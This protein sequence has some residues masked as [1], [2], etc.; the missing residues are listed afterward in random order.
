MFDSIPE[1]L[2]ALQQ[3]VC[4]SI[5]PPL[6]EGEKPRKV[7]YIPGTDSMAASN[8]P[9]DWRS[10]RA[11]LRDV[12]EGKRQYVGFC[13]STS[14]PYV[15]ID[16]DDPDDAEQTA[17][18]NRFK[19]YAQRSISGS[20][21]HLI[22]K[23][24]FDGSGKHPKSP[25]AGLFKE[26]RFCL[27]T[28]DTLEGRDTIN[29]VEDADLQAVHRWLG[30][31][32][33]YENEELVEYKS[34]IPDQTV[35]DMGIDRFEKFDALCSGNWQQFDEYKNDHSAADHAFIAMLC[36][37]TESNEQVRKLF[38]YSGMWN[39]ERAAKKAGHGLVGYVNRTISKIR[40]KQAHN[41]MLR[42]SVKLTFLEAEIEQTPLTTKTDLI[43]SLPDGL[44]KDI[45]RYSYASSYYPLQE[46]SVAVAFC[47]VSV[48]CGRAYLTPSSQG[49][50][51][52]L[53]LVG[54]SSCG[55]DEFQDGISRIFGALHKRGLKS[56]MDIF[57]GELASGEAIEQVFS[58]RR[59]YLTFM[60][61]FG[62][63]F[64]QIVAPHAPPH[65]DNLKR[66]LLNSFNS[67]G[68]NG[69]VRTRERAQRS[70]NETRVIERPCLVVAGETVPEK[71][72]GS[73]SQS[74]IEDGF[75]QRFTILEADADS[76]SSRP[77][78]NYGK[79]PP[80]KLLDTLERLILLT[81][82]FDVESTNG[83]KRPTLL[84]ASSDAASAISDFE[85][86][87]R[88]YNRRGAGGVADR[89][90]GNRAAL[91]V[92]RYAS[93][94]AV[95]CDFYAPIIEMKHVD[96]ALRFVNS[97]DS[98]LIDKFKA[99]E[100]GLGQTKQEAEIRKAIHE[101]RG[102]TVKYRKSLGMNKK[103]AEASDILPLHVLKERVVQ[104]SA[105]VN[106]RSGAVTALERCVESMVKSGEV[107]KLSSDYA[108][109][110]FDH[111][112]GILLCVK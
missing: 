5:L 108:I 102:Q 44:V 63:K 20:G 38:A 98:R 90:L 33:D 111:T 21:R 72:Y 12:E 16:L 54:L 8:R 22:C 49:L 32:N 28:G 56:P 53:I 58:S 87:K 106:D 71:L 41:E 24:N 48:L 47:V 7:P 13:F 105:F 50:N 93:L 100:I 27:M 91:K 60:T 110:H 26:N 25:D 61:E 67:A 39:E 89:E 43:D 76:W 70:E 15:F 92:M 10:F 36:E 104:S 3:W 1:E 109:A 51:I 65:I 112:R 69:A 29:V 2:K 97:A 55:K 34:N 11:A 77:N 18:F 40:S 23:G 107:V 14:D 9:R 37:L 95:G 57:G 88:E 103:V 85:F 46:A 31:G 82:T 6:S 83:K 35:I 52:W 62:K 99:G 84:A 78:V 59:R 30:G 66:G 81:D 17:I 45:A 64:K 19:T 96:Y 80:K 79:E 101:L 86:E 42:N 68:I 74:D 4:F 73:M 75:L 94:L